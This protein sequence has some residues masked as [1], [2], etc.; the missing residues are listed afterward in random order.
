MACALADIHLSAHAYDR[1]EASAARAVS[2][3]P[4]DA[5]ARVLLARARIG[6]GRYVEA[7]AATGTAEGRAIWLQRG[8]ARYRLG[9][10]AEARRELERTARDG[11]MPGEAAVWYALTDVKLGR[12]EQARALLQKLAATR[13][14]PPLTWVALGQALESLDEIGRGGDRL[15]NRHRV[16]PGRPRGSRGPGPP[17]PVPRSRRRRRPRAAEGGGRRPLRPRDAPGPGCRAAR[18]RTP[19]AGPRRARRGALGPPCRSGRARH[20]LRGV[21]RR[22]S[23]ARGS[24]GRG[25]RAG[26]RSLEAGLAPGRGTGSPGAGRAPR[27]SQARGPGG[28][29]GR[30]RPG[31]ARRAHAPGGAATAV[32]GALQVAGVGPGRRRNARFRATR[33]RLAASPAW[34][35]ASAGASGCP[36]VRSRR[37]GPEPLSWDASAVVLFPCGPFPPAPAARPGRRP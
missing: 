1:A 36:S 25:S 17:A 16:R 2:L 31:R 28:E 3:S 6:R 19:G 29:G 26:P 11:R 21:A 20:A 4:G 9:Q 14:P 33:G 15:P 7:L 13:S 32:G 24:P 5:S 23:A 35:A 10:M 22:G 27:R 34:S 8:I 37:A 12:A 18:H 30:A